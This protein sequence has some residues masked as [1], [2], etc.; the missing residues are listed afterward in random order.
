MAAGATLKDDQAP[1]KH[2]ERKA[3]VRRVRQTR[4]AAME[5]RR[6]RAADL[7][8]QGAIPAEVARRQASVLEHVDSGRR[9]AVQRVAALIEGAN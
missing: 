5:E 8:E 7:F 2:S 4:L 9:R 1:G 6:M 3:T